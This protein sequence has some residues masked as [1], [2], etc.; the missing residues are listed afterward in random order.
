MTQYDLPDI[1][2]SSD[3]G[4]DLA[5]FLN[6][7]RPAVISSHAGAN[8]PSYALPGTLW[9]DNDVNKPFY[10]NGSQDIGFVVSTDLAAYLPL[11]GGSLTGPLGGTAAQFQTMAVGGVLEPG[12]AFSVAGA[13]RVAGAFNATGTITGNGLSTASNV[14]FTGSGG[15]V[16]R[17]SLSGTNISFVINESLTRLLPDIQDIFAMTMLAG[18]PTGYMINLLGLGGSVSM[19]I[20]AD[21][22]SDARLKLNIQETKED[23]GSIIDELRVVEFDWNSRMEKVLGRTHEP[24]GL[25][26]QEVEQV[27]PRMV[28]HMKVD[29]EDIC[30]LH[31][32]AL[33][34]YLLKE[35]QELRKRVRYLETHS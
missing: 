1:D 28:T 30:A 13:A 3:T 31:Y 27:L 32:P 11:S 6:A 25:I 20:Y 22:V 21:V 19:N 35:I 24:I 16:F 18:G 9:Y 29:D 33:I 23:T 7:W 15:N 2:P 17:P 4:T 10:F 12:F 26:A 8:R 5:G 34:P 14:T